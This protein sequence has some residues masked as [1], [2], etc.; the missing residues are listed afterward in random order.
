MYGRVL[1]GC[2]G[3]PSGD[4]GGGEGMINEDNCGVTGTE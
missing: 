3:K 4:M 1:E 2:W